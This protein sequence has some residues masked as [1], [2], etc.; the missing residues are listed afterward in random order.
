MYRGIMITMNDNSYRKAVQSCVAE[1][2][3]DE[4]GVSTVPP[5][6]QNMVKAIDVLTAEQV[7]DVR[8]RNLASLFVEFDGRTYNV[9]ERVLIPS[10]AKPVLHGQAIVGIPAVSG[11]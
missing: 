8:Q 7:A 4:H 1:C 5:K 3:K 6:T 11:G 2:V 10:E 9:Q